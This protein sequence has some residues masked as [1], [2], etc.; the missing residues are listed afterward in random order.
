MECRFTLKRIRDMVKTH[1]QKGK[2]FEIKIFENFATIFGTLLIPN[3]LNP[4]W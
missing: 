4:F 1:S 2:V 3:K